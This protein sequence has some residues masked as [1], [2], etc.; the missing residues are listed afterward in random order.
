[1]NGSRYMLPVARLLLPV[2]LLAL[3]T[4]GVASS[5]SGDGYDLSWNTVDG[6]GY[7]WS[8]GGSYSLGGTA[9]QP[10]AGALAGGPYTLR[11][12]FWAGGEVPAM[13]YRIYLP[14]T[15]RRF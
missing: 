6:G 3:L 10:D 12:G 15:L 5:Q 4:V 9:G 11:G 8:E 7:T 1:M 13:E 14:L 2:V